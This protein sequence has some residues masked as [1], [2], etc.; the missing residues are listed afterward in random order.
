MK[1]VLIIGKDSYIGTHIQ[2][3]LMQWGCCVEQLDVLHSDWKCYDY[4]SYDVIVS[5][6]AIVH[7]PDCND[8]KLY[9]KVNVDMP[10]GIAEKAKSQGVK[11][12]IFLSSMA[13]Y[14]V[15]KDLKRTVIDKKTPL[16]P[17]TMYGRS[18]LLA[19]EHLNR[20]Q[21]ADFDV[22]IVRPPNVYGK[23]CRGRY[24]EGFATITRMLPIIPMAYSNVKQ[25]MLYIDNLSEFIK[26]AIELKLHGVFSLQDEISVSANEIFTIMA[27]SFGKK[28][29]LSKFLGCF[30][31]LFHFIPLVRKV[32]G[33]VEYDTSLS[34]IKNVNYVV[35]PF[36][37]GIRRT[38][39]K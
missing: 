1:R 20:L 27:N 10:V 4:S 35:V 38:V 19:E 11:M 6:A 36:S 21:D 39:S 34:N 28:I 29:I 18:K 16:H 22:I 12:F 33:G 13:V 9:Q 31:Y 26:Q 24:I 7:R 14:G 37:E 23:G 8:W 3:W 25:S 2:D 32:F 30:V 17:K 15:E 5:V